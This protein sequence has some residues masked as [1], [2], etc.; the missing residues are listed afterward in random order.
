MCVFAVIVYSGVLTSFQPP[1]F[2]A[3]GALPLPIEAALKVG[4]EADLIR[5]HQVFD[6]AKI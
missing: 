5:D 2:G 1:K 3:I 4:T 6:L